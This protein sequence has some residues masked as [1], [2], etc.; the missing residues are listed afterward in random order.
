MKKTILLF[1]AACTLLGCQVIPEADRLIPIDAGE[2]VSNAL[3]TECTGFLCVNCP[4]AAT[5]AHELL[6]AY[7]GN[8]V[9]VELHPK[10]NAFCQTTIAAYD[11]TCPEADT[12]YWWLG[13]T[14]TTGFPTG[15]INFSSGLQDYFNWS[16]LVNIAVRQ[17]RQGRMSL[18]C[19][20]TEG[21]KV[22]VNYHVDAIS[23]DSS[24]TGNA[25]SLRTMLWLIEDD[26]VGPQ[27]MPDGSTNMNYVHN[28]V[29]RGSVLPSIWGKV[30]DGK[31][32]NL[33]DNGMETVTFE[34][35]DSINGQAIQLE[36]CSVVGIVADPETNEVQ[37][38]QLGHIN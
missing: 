13:G 30:T 17:H 3:L 5:T 28:H 2:P 31:L 25:T 26:I 34:V 23:S 12:L 15:A 16:S 14:S 32:I 10:S 20:L 18:S 9:V 6:E 7:E 19:Q 21:R 36:H 4:N 35:P 38:V 24:L 37:D 33:P 11:Y 22:Q 1:F 29:L 8:L 27:M